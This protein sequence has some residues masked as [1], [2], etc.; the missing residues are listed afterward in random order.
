M[1]QCEIKNVTTVEF[2]IHT[3]T[4][5]SIKNLYIKHIEWQVNQ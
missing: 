4:S 1:I 2:L 5:R 3:V